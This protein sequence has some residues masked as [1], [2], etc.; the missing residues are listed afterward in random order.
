MVILQISIWLTPLT[1]SSKTI[2]YIQ[3][4]TYFASAILGLIT[5]LSLRKLIPKTLRRA[6]LDKFREIMRKA[7][8]AVKAVSLRVLRLFGINTARYKKHKDERKFIFDL[9]DIGIIK[10]IRS[11]KSSVKYKDLTENAEKIR[12]IYIKYMIKRIK[13]GYK[14]PPQQTPTETKE[15]LQLVENDGKLVDLYNGAR[16]SGGSVIISDTDVSMALGLVSGK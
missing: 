5:L 10:K 15:D 14:L 13:G 7:L 12:F 16:Y 1:E 3:Q 2:R 9:D 6:A 8:S 4:L 11:L